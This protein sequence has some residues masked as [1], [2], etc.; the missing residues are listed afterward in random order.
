MSLSVG[1]RIEVL[2]TLECQGPV[3]VGGWEDTAEANLAVAR[4]GTGRPVLPGTSLAG[5]LRAYLNRF[6]R[7]RP[8]VPALFGD[9]DEGGRPSWIR[10]DDAHLIAPDIIAGSDAIP[11]IPVVR[12]GVGIDRASAS[13]AA[14]FLFTRELLPAGTRFALRLVADTPT[15]AP[16]VDYPGGWPALVSDA[17]EA[18]VSGLRHAQVPIGAGRGRGHG[19]VTL[20]DVEVRSADLS[21]PAGMVAWLTGQPTTATP[22]GEAPA[23]GQLWITVRWR[24]LSPVLVRDSVPGTV[25]DILPLTDVHADGETRLLL[26]GSSIRGAIRAYAE[27]IVRTLQ[28]ED[29]PS[30]F[31]EVLRRPPPGVDVLFGTA[32]AR[33]RDRATADGPPGD[34]D[35]GTERGRRGVLS[36]ADCR[37]AGS[38]DAVDWN[39]VLSV[40]P[41]SAAGTGEEREDRALR[42]TE[43]DAARAKLGQHLDQIGDR[44]ALRISD[45]VA[46][47]RWTGGA[48]DHRLFSVLDPD[49]TVE[50]EPISISVDV[51]RLERHPSPDDTAHLALPLLLLVLRDL[52]DGWL[53]LG[54]GG[55]RGRGQIEVTGVTFDGTEL[56]DPWASLV[57]RDLDSVLN[58]PPPE[59]VDAMTAWAAHFERQDA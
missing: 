38:V 4:D 12:D 10:V 45:H 19:R 51:A 28:G 17:V 30:D 9:D 48:G 41:A 18:I 20:C 24:P 55:T 14:G 5:A 3:H 52:R 43:R 57:G 42:N 44:V 16:G 39:A 59:V 2:G 54:Y 8:A 6:D 58:D 7:F 31:N 22:R 49:P 1:T 47:D 27:R 36:F 56:P 34:R 29:A 46:I 53:S 15:A 25:V 40:A 35:G 37:S 11:T 33:R 23:D 21:D 26:P 32:P 13:A 50:W